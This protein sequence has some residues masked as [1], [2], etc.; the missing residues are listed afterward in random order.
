MRVRK[1]KGQRRCWKN[2][3]DMTRKKAR[4]HGMETSVSFCADLSREAE[5][6]TPGHGCLRPVTRLADRWKR[7]CRPQLALEQRK[8]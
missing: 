1:P 8:G 2:R 4:T 5:A 6:S 7:T 3:N